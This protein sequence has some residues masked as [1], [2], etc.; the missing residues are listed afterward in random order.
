MSWFY[1]LLYE[2]SRSAFVYIKAMSVPMRLNHSG[3]GEEE[4]PS[5][6]LDIQ[7]RACM[8]EKR[9]RGGVQVR[10]LVNT[11]VASVSLQNVTLK[12]V[13]DALWSSIVEGESDLRLAVY[14]GCERQRLRQAKYAYYRHVAL[15]YRL[16]FYRY[17]QTKKIAVE[18]VDG[19]DFTDV[20]I[21]SDHNTT[22]SARQHL[23]DM[24]TLTADDIRVFN[25]ELQASYVRLLPPINA[26]AFG[27]VRDE[28]M[29]VGGYDLDEC[30][31]NYDKD[32]LTT[33]L[34]V[35]TN[36]FLR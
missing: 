3:F 14:Y 1:H 22:L 35:Q 5:Q 32:E 31:F 33:M 27:A 19:I 7:P 2:T 18:P 11:S 21:F 26:M 8:L 28:N 20:S 16:K 36:S 25:Q 6:A 9:L 13:S 17:A 4:V 15:V 29:P 12:V 10:D 34:P 30:V 23:P 24:P